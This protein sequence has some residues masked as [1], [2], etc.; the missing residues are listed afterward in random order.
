MG[1]GP[2]ISSAMSTFL[3]TALLIIAATDA[4]LFHGRCSTTSWSL[5]D[6]WQ[7]E[8]SISG[9]QIPL[10]EAGLTGGHEGCM[11]ACIAETGFFCRAVWVNTVLST[12]DLSIKPLG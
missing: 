9:R 6:H 2:V 5:L 1:D 11:Q 4:S 3:A 10:A 7:G 8:P 12:C